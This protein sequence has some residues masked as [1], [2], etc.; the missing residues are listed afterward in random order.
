[1]YKGKRLSTISPEELAALQGEFVG[2]DKDGDG[3][4]SVEELETLL[5]SLRLKLRK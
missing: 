2:L 3:K 5:K 4:I 1:M